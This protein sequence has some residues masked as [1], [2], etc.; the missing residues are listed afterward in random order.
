MIRYSEHDVDAILER[1]V[2]V[3]LG[4]L[5]EKGWAL[6]NGLHP[7][8]GRT[9]DEREERVRAALWPMRLACSAYSA[10]PAPPGERTRVA[11]L[12]E[13]FGLT[14]DETDAE[15]LSL[16]KDLPPWEVASDAP[17]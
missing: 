1:S 16:W 4:W 6:G 5:R 12:L 7:P 2:E 17:E 11:A 10:I 8:A 13:L 14:G 9:L 3:C 15:I